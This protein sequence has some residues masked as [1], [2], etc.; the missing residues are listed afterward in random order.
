MLRGTARR[1]AGTLHRHM[2]VLLLVNPAASS[3]STYRRLV[4]EA[5]LRERHDLDVAFTEHRDHATAIA[6]AAADD[7]VDVV[8]VFAGDGTLNEAANGVLGSPTAL[9]PMPGGS[10]NVYARTIG[11]PRAD[12]TRAARALLDALARG[13]VRRVGVGVAGERAFL[14]HLGI[15]FDAE[16]VHRVERHGRRKRWWAQGLFAWEILRTSVHQRH[17]ADRRVAVAAAGERI[18]GCTVAVV[19]KTSPYTF[20]GPRR[21]EIAPEASLDSALS[22]T[23]IRARRATTVLRAL[24]SAIGRGAALR[25]H[26]AVERRAGLGALTVSAPAP[27]PWQVDGDYLGE[28]DHLDVRYEPGALRLVLPGGPPGRPGQ[29]VGAARAG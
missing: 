28:T 5:A 10:T 7:G 22:L 2:R 13:S 9:A 14:F 17:L 19:S 12:D 23:A 1:P 24:T 11:V 29:A 21:I 18:D 25:H 3:V 27:F 6:R 4:V 15:G 26:P 16:V 20:V 8:V